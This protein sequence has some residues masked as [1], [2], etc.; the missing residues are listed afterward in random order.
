MTFGWQ[1]YYRCRPE[2]A[3]PGRSVNGNY[4]ATV[5]IHAQ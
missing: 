4:A 1:L 5:A 3:V 2:L